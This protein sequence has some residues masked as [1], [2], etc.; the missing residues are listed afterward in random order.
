[1]ALGDNFTASGSL[2]VTAA[3]E[4]EHQATLYAKRMTE[5]PSDLQQRLD[6]VS[7]T[8]GQ[9][10]YIGFG[11]RS[12]ASSTNGWLIHKFTYDGSNFLTLRQTAFDTWDNRASATYA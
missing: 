6:Y 8:D 4:R 5:I 10:I 1:M 2:K 12:L 3:E 11:P 9:P 7:R